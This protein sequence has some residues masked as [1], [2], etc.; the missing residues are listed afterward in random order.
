MAASADENLPSVQIAEGNQIGTN[1]IVEQKTEFMMGFQMPNLATPP[2]FVVF[3]LANS[4]GQ[5]QQ[6]VENVLKE[7]KANKSFQFSAAPFLPL[8]HSASIQSAQ[9]EEE[10][11]QKNQ[12]QIQFTV[13][14]L[15]N[16]FKQQQRIPSRHHHR[17]NGRL[18]FD[19]PMF[20]QLPNWHFFGDDRRL[21]KIPPVIPLFQI[22]VE[23]TLLS[24]VPSPIWTRQLL[25]LGQLDLK[26]RGGQR[27]AA[28]ENVPLELTKGG[29]ELEDS[30]EENEDESLPPC[31]NCSETE[32][33]LPP[34]SG[35]CPSS[36]G[37]ESMSSGGTMASTPTEGAITPL[38]TMTP[39]MVEENGESFDQLKIS[40]TDE[41]SSNSADSSTPNSPPTFDRR[42]IR[43]SKAIRDAA[44]RLSISKQFSDDICTG[45]FAAVNK[46]PG[47]TKNKIDNVRYYF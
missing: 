42:T 29:H 44:F 6:K 47:K 24:I 43:M 45:N 28:I 40:A 25:L 31:S 4:W 23:R 39:E 20:R 7:T 22:P 41:F 38:R 3:E 8:G 34:D 13:V 11:P 14:Q 19:N 37:V 46:N 27:Q 36:S 18:L 35:G 16:K 1:A 2:Q 30:E 33:M 10:L 12:Q 9:N 5:K 26:R 15:G 21:A 32:E 17:P